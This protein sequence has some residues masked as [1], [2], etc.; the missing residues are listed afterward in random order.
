M[1]V[2]W[3][4]S[5]GTILVCVYGLVPFLDE[6]VVPEMNP[7]IRITFGTLSRIGWALAVGWIIFACLNGY[8]G[9]YHFNINLYREFVELKYIFFKW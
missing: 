8:G 4:L 6:E 9:Y 1:I 5:I 3:T 7:L 2:G